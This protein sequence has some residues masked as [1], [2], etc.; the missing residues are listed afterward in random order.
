MSILSSCVASALSSPEVETMLLAPPMTASVK[1]G[2]S[3]G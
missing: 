3:A 1:S 2:K